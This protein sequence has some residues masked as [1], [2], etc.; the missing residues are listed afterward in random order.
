MSK[1]KKFILRLKLC[2]SARAVSAQVKVARR[3]QA[4]DLTKFRSEGEN[5]TQ[6]Q[7]PKTG[8]L[9]RPADAGSGRRRKRQSLLA[10]ESRS[11]LRLARRTLNR[12]PPPSGNSGSFALSSANSSVMIR[13]TREA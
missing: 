6:I 5:R 3:E 7:S 4:A 10:M 8:A 9:Q 2:G 1:N 13:R 11:S 12:R